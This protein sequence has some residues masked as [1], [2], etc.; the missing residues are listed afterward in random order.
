M[1]ECCGVVL[2]VTHWR[3]YLW[4]RH[5]TCC[6]DHQALTYLYKMQD[7]SNMLTRWAIALQNYDFTVKHV[8][9]KLNVVPDMLSRAFS[10]VNGETIPSEPRLAAICRNVPIDGPYHPPGPREYELSASNLHDVAPVESDRELFMSAVSVFPTVDPAELVD[11]QKEEFVRIL[12][13]S[14]HQYRPY[15]LME[16]P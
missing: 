6:T 8:A 10:E 16:N 14:E 11:L 7:T 15:S 13:T 3:P 12:S 2:A 4:G 5:F 9:G 1:K